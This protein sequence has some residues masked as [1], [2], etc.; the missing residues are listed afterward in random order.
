LNLQDKV[1]D[2]LFFFSYLASLP[3]KLKT[4]IRRENHFPICPENFRTSIEPA[5][6]GSASEFG[7]ILLLKV[8]P[9]AL[10]NPWRVTFNPFEESKRTLRSLPERAALPPK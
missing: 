6:R 4:A 2:K 5:E 7:W 8:D 1:R 10:A 9:A 3:T